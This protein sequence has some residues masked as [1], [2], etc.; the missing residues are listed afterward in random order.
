MHQ[1][2]RHA[3]RRAAAGLQA[4]SVR[5]PELNARSSLLTVEHHRQLIETDAGAAVTQV[6]GNL[7]SNRV[8]LATAVNDNEVVAVGVHLHERQ[9]HGRSCG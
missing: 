4:C 1:A 7:R 9:G 3:T 2:I 8:I 5:V 6:A